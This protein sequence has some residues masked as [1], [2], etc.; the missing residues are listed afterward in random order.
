MKLVHDALAAL[1]ERVSIEWHVS[2]LKRSGP[3]ASTADAAIDV[4]FG[5]GKVTYFV[6]CKSVVDRKL[7]IDQV[8]R[9]LVLTGSPGLLIAPY[10]S[11][12]LAEHCRLRDLQF[13]DTCGNAY[14]HASGFFVFITGE[15]NAQ[16]QSSRAPKGLTSAA[17]LR[18][19]FV[20]LSKPELLNAPFKEIAGNAGVSLG[21]AYNV[22]EDLEQRGHLIKRAGTGRRQLLEP[23]RLAEEWAINYPTTLRTKL[24]GRRF[25]APEPHWWKNADLEGLHAVWGAEVAAMK[26][27][28]YLK[29]LTQTIY[30][31]PSHLDSVI[32]RLAQQYR[33]RPDPEGDIEI[34]EKFWHLHADTKPDLAPPLLVY[35][36]LLALLD[37][38]AREAAD[39][40]RETLIDGAFDQV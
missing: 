3:G 26:L 9:Q 29:P 6:E 13:I 15:R 20:L 37:P 17:A 23:Q 35:A 12:E 19:V 38:R 4:S 34:L 1:Q 18:V 22:L 40:I 10:L 21:T 36:E 5:N 11:R 7:Q 16:G 31:I 2:E 8:Q 14:L 30:V 39:S 28:G 32:K 27:T 33:I 24:Q 25:S